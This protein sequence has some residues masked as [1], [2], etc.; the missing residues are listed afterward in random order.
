VQYLVEIAL[1]I[2][3]WASPIV[4][5]WHQVASTVPSDTIKSIYLANPVTLAVLGF[6]RVFWVAGDA[7]PSPSGLVGSLW[8]ALGV[9][10]VLVLV[11]QR[12]FA[13]LQGNFAQE[14]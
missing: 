4:Y 6:Q 10:V 11:A 3:M 1:M 7:Q 12:V 13:R 5:A 2:A 8:I 14:L 9:G